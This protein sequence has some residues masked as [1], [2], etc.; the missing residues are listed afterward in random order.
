[1]NTDSQIYSY[2]SGVFFLLFVFVLLDE[3][4]AF[5][6]PIKNQEFC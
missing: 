1:M 6:S 5:V 4:Q 2:F 3:N